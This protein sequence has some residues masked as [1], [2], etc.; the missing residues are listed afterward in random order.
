M[1]ENAPD[2]TF[3]QSSEGG[4]IKQDVPPRPQADQIALTNEVRNR[5][6]RN[7][8]IALTKNRPADGGGLLDAFHRI[9]ETTGKTLEVARVSIW[10]VAEDGTAIECLDLYELESHGHSSGGR[11]IAAD[12]PAYF[13][14]LSESELIAADDAHHDPRTCEFSENYLKP[15]GIS[16]MLDVPIRFPKGSSYI[17]CNEHV[18][19]VRSW[20]A[21]EK[22][23]SVA[24][25]NLVSLALESH[26]RVL[27]QREVLWSHQ[28]FQSVAAATNDTI[29]DW[30]LE[31]D[32][33]WWNDGFAN[34]FGWAASEGEVTNQ[35]WIRQIHPEDRNRVVAGIYSAIERGDVHWTDEYR[36]INNDD[37]I[38]YVLDRGQ[39]IRDASGKAI[40]MVGGMTDLSA[41]KAAE[42]E[43]GRSN[44]A[45]RMFSSCN[46]MLIRTT[47]ESDLLAEAC[48][49]AVEIGGYRMAWV[50]FVMEDEAR[51]IVPMAH[52]GAELGY[53]SE[54]DISWADDHPSGLGPAGQAIRSGKEVVF[55]DLIGNPEFS[56]WLEPARKRGYRSVVCLPLSDAKR[57]FGVLCLYAG[58]PH[59]AGE[60]EIKMLHDMAAD[61]AFGIENIRSRL[62]RQRTQD[63]VIKV[64]QAVSS[65]TGTEFFNLLTCNM[66]E[67]L[68]ASGGVIGR[69]NQGGHSI[70][71]LSFVLNGE[72]KENVNY[73]LAG[74]PCE[75][76]INCD[77]CVYERGV[78]KLFPEDRIL[79]DLGIE[80]YAGIPLYDQKGG[81]AGIMAVFYSN[82]V[83]EAAL[84]ESTLRIFATRAASEMDR[85]QA[86]ARIREQ[87]SLLDK[88]Q[89][90]ILVRDLNH[91]VTYWNKSAA[92]LY[93][94]M[95]AEA[96]GRTVGELI[97]R[98]TAAFSLAH[99]RTLSTG[100]WVGEMNQIDKNGRE[101]I[102]E[103]RWTLVRDEQ[104]MPESVFVINTDI[105]E[106]RKLEQQFLRAQRLESIGTLAG[107]IAHD[108]NNILAPIS[109]AIELLKMRVIDGRSAELLDTIAASAKR[110]ADMV[111]QVLSFA[112][113]MDGR[114]VEVHPRQIIAEI[115]NI[116]RDT[117]LENVV[118]QIC[119]SRELW[120]IYGDSTQLHQVLL[121]LCVNARDAIPGGGEIFILADNVQIDATFA[122][123]NLEARE[124]PHVCIQVTDSG[125]GI[126]P[127]IIDKIFDPFFTT[128][129]V[130]KGTGL[131]LS[132][133]LAIV[134]SHGGF[135]RCISKVG[136]GTCFKVYLPARPEMDGAA[137]LPDRVSLP[138]GRGETVLV[139][140]DEAS[141]RQITRETLEAFG[142]QALLAS[143]GSEALARYAEHQAA[144]AVVLTDMTMPIM[145]G[146]AM[147][148]QLVKMNP[149]VR[150]IATSGIVAHGELAR[151]NGS[152]IAHFLPKPYTAETL[153]NSLRMVLA[154]PQEN[155]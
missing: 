70:D 78:Q 19:P 138:V 55:E 115:E 11:L 145:D 118:L 18:G 66:V 44:R 49:I 2:P 39:V 104:G 155:R 86:D 82:A 107:G 91:T 48:R 73:S 84:V 125:N 72:I 141:I 154:N 95:E 60:D 35:A 20:T 36:F 87:A 99:H 100:E 46:E 83:T 137:A 50:G 80:G 65:G 103:G 75:N 31:T 40:R 12:Y 79:A 117:F 74:T 56:R 53:F 94:W 123:I 10:R 54:V 90:A 92:R 27:A 105:T 146:P 8:L 129:A 76:A 114:R 85:Q 112:R 150:I 61:L 3:T 52:A 132:T 29:W 71:T 130:G 17:L 101:L 69:L 4:G 24:I 77:V 111:G 142:Y 63:V 151:H 144:I 67:A 1:N 135:I 147:I 32:A 14:S 21:D 120:T 38:A 102:V 15:L 136:E 7:A 30:N 13:K 93:G 6:Q 47:D 139:V 23:F 116:V 42:I 148:A 126:P 119:A 131:G 34:L 140:D 143:D 153:L 62:E 108:L 106:H 133:S 149:A 9:T 25:A 5:L 64:A 57:S 113:G 89:D 110:G 22:T 128:K 41:Y 59:P 43:L 88:A 28:R 109:M 122:A 124:G 68:G 26:E 127:E 33:L 81:V 121:N 134:K 98:D 152:G 37:S 16:S 96:L 45:L 58:E 51:S 97:Y